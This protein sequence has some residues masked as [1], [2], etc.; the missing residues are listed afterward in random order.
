MSRKSWIF[1]LSLCAPVAAAYF[2]FPTTP[3]SKL[4]LYNGLG[5][6]AVVAMA[7]GIRRNRPETPKAWYFFVAG[8]TSFLTA[9]VLY[10]VLNDILHVEAFPS[11]ADLFYLGMYPLVIT[12]IL[13]LIRAHSPGRDTAGLVDAGITLVSVFAVLWVL[14][15]DSYIVDDSMSNFARV[16]SIAYPV[17]DIALLATIARFALSIRLKGASISLMIGSMI[18][19]LVADVGY[20]VTTLAGTFKTGGLIDL[21][22]MLFY[23]LFAC[24]ALHPSMGEAAEAAP[25]QPGRLTPGRLGLLAVLTIN[26]PVVNLLW[27]AETLIDQVVATAASIALFLLVLGR[28]WLLLNTIKASHASAR[29]DAL[30]DRLTGLANRVLLAEEIEEV[31]EQDDG[32]SLLGVLFIDLDDFKTVNDRLGHNA[33]DIL[34]KEVAQRLINCSSPGDV[35]ARLGGDEFAIL[36]KDLPSE[37]GAIEVAESIVKA[38][39]VPVVLSGGEV[40]CGASIGVAVGRLD[41][42]G[43]ETLLRNADVAM[44]SAKG[45]GKRR[46]EFFEQGMYEESIRRLELRADLQTAL[47]R[48]EM[49]VYYQPIFEV[50][51]Q[52]IVSLE[53]LLRWNHPTQGLISP[54]DF[55]PLAE[56]IGEIV[57]LGKWVLEQACHQVKVWQ[58]ERHECADLGVCVNLSVRQLHDPDLVATV[59]ETLKA[60]GLEPGYLTLELTESVLMHDAEFGASILEELKGLGVKIAIDDFGTGYS[61]FSYLRRFAVDSI[62]IDRSFISDLGNNDTAI[63]LACSIIDLAKALSLE[64]VAEGIEEAEQL[65]ALSELGCDFGQGFCVAKPQPPRAIEQ[66]FDE[67]ELRK[68]D[69]AE[70]AAVPA[71]GVARFKTEVLHGLEAFESVSADL[72]DLHSFAQVPIMA[73]SRWLGVWAQ[74]HNTWEPLSVLVRSERSGTL[75]AAALL[76]QR[77][78]LDA[79]EVVGIG[80]GGSSCTRLASRDLKSAEV[81]ARTI[82]DALDSIPSRWKLELEQLPHNDPV[83]S[84]LADQLSHSHLIGDLRIPRVTFSNSSASSDSY[85]SRNMRKQIRRAYQNLAERGINIDI[86]FETDPSVI[87]G[88]LPELAEAHIGRDHLKRRSSDLDDPA[89]KVFWYQVIAAHNEI[90]SVEIATLRLDGE[91]GAYVVGFIDGQSWRV[92]DGHMVTR[93]SSYSPGRVLESAVVDRVVADKKF[94]ELDWMTGV[95]AGKILCST[96]SEPRTRLIA[97]SEPNNECVVCRGL[98]STSTEDHELII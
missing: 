14:V 29:H 90:N 97:F 92:F 72:D 18:F 4:V 84:F 45:K 48:G 47:D 27:G 52:K 17:M 13:L 34:L 20:S 16:T 85:L 66:F 39:D 31:F 32:D 43:Y 41:S 61:S 86:R 7:V 49:E 83:A 21:F 44:Y 2:L 58:V 64:T 35:V 91:L 59:F 25:Q 26:V 42:S 33:G 60:S 94:S 30:H 62:K 38:L 54:L 98:Y 23:A 74:A 46:F 50:N 1:Y 71:A 87:A 76:A 79:L 11:P 80:H 63:A 36:L 55:I 9:D 22:W 82:K 15:M 57:K 8:M 95:E 96:D 37:S 93:F 78:N 56:E 6:A 70:E 3:I 81:L 65:I 69:P 53:A 10:Y 5:L 19:L 68:S 24:A 28:I 40:V 88:L 77:F 75:E 12:G 89:A 73:R 51:G 67:L